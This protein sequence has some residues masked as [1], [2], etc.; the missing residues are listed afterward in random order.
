[1]LKV[2]VFGASAYETWN[3]LYQE[4]INLGKKL[5]K[6]G[7]E[8]W[9]GGYFGLMAAV[10]RGAHSEGGIVRGIISKTFSFR[11]GENPWLT[12]T[13]EAE[14]SIER[15]Q[16]MLT[17]CDVAIAL[18]GSIGTL[19]EIL[20]LLTL[21]KVRESEMPLIAWKKP[22]E[23]L[24]NDWKKNGFLDSEILSKVIFTHNSKEIFEQNLLPTR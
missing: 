10:S 18:P 1:M 17:E 24:L 15:L 2:V 20:M 12:H 6:S 11:S 23:N 4:A 22:Y 16:I 21:W 5:A 7:H 8:V 13:V 14:N 9:N 19:N 3:P